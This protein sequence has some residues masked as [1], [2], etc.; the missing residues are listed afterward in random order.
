[1]ASESGEGQTEGSNIFGVTDSIMSKHP[2]L[3]GLG[4]PATE[5]ESHVNE[6]DV[7]LAVSRVPR[8]T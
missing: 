5:C 8:D 3:K 6:R 2:E 1:M 7:N 4:R